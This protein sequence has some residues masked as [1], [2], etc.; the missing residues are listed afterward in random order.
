MTGVPA[1]SKL[2][3]IPVTKLTEVE[4]LLGKK[5]AQNQTPYVVVR[6]PNAKIEAVKGILNDG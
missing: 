3:R 5:L 1:I 4:K 2:M 6:V